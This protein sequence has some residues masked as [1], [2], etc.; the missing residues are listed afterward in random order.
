VLK[1]RPIH[2]APICPR[3]ASNALLDDERQSVADL[4]TWLRYY[5]VWLEGGAVNRIQKRVIEKEYHRSRLRALRLDME[6]HDSLDQ[7]T[8]RFGMSPP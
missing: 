5:E 6:Y 8:S 1:N 4:E 7:F 3:F 2:C